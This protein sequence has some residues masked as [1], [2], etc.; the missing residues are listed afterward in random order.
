MKRAMS[1]SAAIIDASGLILGRMAS[2]IA[3][4]LL[5]GDR[6]F[7]VN[8]EKAT[9]SGKRLTVIGVAK[10]FL[11]VGHP[12]KGPFHLRRP[13]LIVRR[14]VRG[15]LPWT[16]PK[17]QDAYRRLRV[18]VGMP[19][20]FQSREAQTIPEAKAQKLRCPYLTVGELAEGIGWS[21]GE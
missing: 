3:K 16:K 6:I 17:G 9:I 11:E 8:A 20:E 12:G 2:N 13:D 10:T 5:Q 18:F 4:R 21:R 15:M 19:E 1:E 7:V 14:T